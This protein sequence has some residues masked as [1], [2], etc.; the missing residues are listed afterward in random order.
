VK[1]ALEVY[2]NW[3]QEHPDDVA[4]RMSAANTLQKNLQDDEAS[5]HYEEVLK[6]DADNAV[7]LNNQAW[8]LREKNP[9]KALE[10]ARRAST[11]AP[12]SGEV[13]DTLAVIEYLRKDYKRATLSIE[14][15][16][17]ASP[18]NPSIIYHGAMIAAVTGDKSG[19]R[20]TLSKLLEVDRD[21][22]ERE[23]ARALLAELDN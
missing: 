19:A 13:L 14:H 11:L 21:F 18:N 7:A 12:Q 2:Q 22:P 3:L 6:A 23:E 5:L 4:A 16:L 8:I 1:G 10:Y 15:A 20:T 9:E 17:Q